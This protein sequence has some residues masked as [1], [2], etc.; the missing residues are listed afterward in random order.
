MVLK[1]QIRW[2]VD[3][4]IQMSKMCK[5][6]FEPEA[7]KSLFSS[8]SNELKLPNPLQWRDQIWTQSIIIKQKQGK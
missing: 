1:N 7:T 5:E 6:S 8:V 4:G 3:V 2:D